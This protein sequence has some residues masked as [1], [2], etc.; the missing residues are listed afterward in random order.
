MLENRLSK[1]RLNK[2]LFSSLPLPAVRGNAIFY[3]ILRINAR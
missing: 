3:A 1:T 2:W